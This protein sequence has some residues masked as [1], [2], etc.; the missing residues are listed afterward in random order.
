MK[1]AID[2]SEI[3][4]F[5]FDL[6]G[7]ILPLHERFYAVWIDT[8]S[9]FS[10]PSLSWDEFMRRIEN[11]TLMETIDPTNQQSFMK[12]FLSSYSQY[13]SFNDTLILGAKD[14]LT[15]LKK[16]GFLLAL[17][18]G[19]ISST[20]ELMNEMKNHDL[21]NLFSIVTAQN[22]ENVKSNSLVSKEHQI[23]YI[24]KN[25]NISPEEAIMVGDYL[26]DIRSGKEVGLKT[27]ALLSSK[28]SVE[29][30]K[31]E[32]PDLILNSISDLSEVVF[33]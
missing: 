16:A 26:T 23:K 22:A 15:Q 6:D 13:G 4:L 7:T 27:I 29:I 21:D 25:L 32:N 14:T 2:F 33:C 1:K 9:K 10:L 3:K 28:V 19:R 11:D 20:T 17:A 30:I 24:L 12:A 5:I 18:T 8:L 31:K